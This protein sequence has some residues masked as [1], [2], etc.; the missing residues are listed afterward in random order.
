MSANNQFDFASKIAVITGAGTGMG[1]DLA[2]QLAAAGC[3]LALGDIHNDT[4]AETAALAASA[5]PDGLVIS[6]HVCDVSDEAS[7]VAWRDALLVAHDTDHVHLVFNNAG[8]AGGGSFVLD[9]RD[10]WERTFDICWSGVY[11]CCRAFLPLLIAAPQGHII[12]TS[13]V[14]GFWAS[15][16]PTRPHT[17]YSAAKFAVKGFTEALVTDLRLNAP[18]VKA[19]VVIPGHIGTSIALNSV[20]VRGGEVDAAVQEVENAFRNT[21]PLTSAQAAT[22]ILEKVAAGEWRIL[23]GDDAYVL[24]ELVRATPEEAYE[25]SFVERM[26]SEGALPGLVATLADTAL[27]ETAST[28]T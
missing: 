9:D 11:Y 6:T 7:V 4:V 21:A 27:N 2:V 26:L 17:A 25:L 8:I 3:H 18:H 16:G 15:M 12:N 22:V 19:S 10:S 13:S 5:G 24:D 14:N 1:R 20:K 23:V 28:E